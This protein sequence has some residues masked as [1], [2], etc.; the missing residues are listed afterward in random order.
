MRSVNSSAAAHAAF[1]GTSL[2]PD[3]SSSFLSCSGGSLN[4]RRFLQA[5]VA[6][7]L[8]AGA[9]DLATPA[10]ADAAAFDRSIVRELAREA[11]KKPYKAPDTKLPDNLKDL[12]YDHYRQIRFLPERALWRGERLLFEV[13]FFHRGFFYAPRIDIYEVV[14]GQATR[15]GYRAG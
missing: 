9:T 2:F 11:A 14:N 6:L 13:Q 7:P 15:I 1:L 10:H 12:D 4:R 5:A 3:R 8:A